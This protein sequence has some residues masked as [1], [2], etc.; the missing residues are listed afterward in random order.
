MNKFFEI[1]IR[2][3]T[4][5]KIALEDVGKRLTYL[6][7]SVIIKDE[8]YLLMH[9]T[10]IF[11]PYI[12]NY[13]YPVE[14]AKEY[15]D[16]TL[17]TFQIRTLDSN[18]MDYLCDALPKQETNELLVVQVN[19][20]IIY[21]RNQLT[22]L[23]SITPTIIKVEEG[24]YWR[25][26]NYELQDLKEQFRNHSIKKWNT[27]FPN[28]KIEQ[29]D[30]VPVFTE[31]RHLNK[32]MPIKVS[33]KNINLLGDKFEFMISDDYKSQQIAFLILCTGLEMN[34]RGF[35]F[36]NGKWCLAKSEEEKR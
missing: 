22:K 36:Y 12:F 2:V 6:V 24:V 21:K 8:K 11:K 29:S 19:R 25:N 5:T 35:G 3:Y 9:K 1:N 20:K 16:E 17:Y 26:A 27:F 33:Y 31:I 32:D 7:D 10:N 4:K 15:K 30:N 13:L 28:R 23:Y 18:L 14:K 34:T